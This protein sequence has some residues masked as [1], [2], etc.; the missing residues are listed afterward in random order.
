MG[1]KDN[2]N[3]KSELLDE[4]EKPNRDQSKIK[5]LMYKIKSNNK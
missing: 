1:F 5:N 4:L 3:Q 2:F